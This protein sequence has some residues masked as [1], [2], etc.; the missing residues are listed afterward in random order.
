MLLRCPPIGSALFH[1]PPSLSILPNSPLFMQTTPT[2]R[3]VN[4]MHC[5]GGSGRVG[6][7]GK[8]RPLAS[9][10]VVGA[11]LRTWAK[12][13]TSLLR[14][15][16]LFASRRNHKTVRVNGEMLSR[17]RSAAVPPNLFYF[18]SDSICISPSC[19]K[20]I[21]HHLQYLPLT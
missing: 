6:R 13:L 10:G 8:A 4:G 15:P 5:S 7:R 11:C 21:V 1:F 9:R 2:R 3:P 12:Y 18:W 19:I 17:I 14:P 20:W 16:S